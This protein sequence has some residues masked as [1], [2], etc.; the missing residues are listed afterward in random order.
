MARS[1]KRMRVSCAMCSAMSPIR[2][3]D[4]LMRSAL[5]TMR[6]SRA[7]GCWRARISI[8]S[9]SRATAFSSIIAS[10]SMTSSASATSLG[11]EGARG[12]VDRDRDEVGDLDE[13]VLNVLEGLV[14]DFAHVLHRFL[15]LGGRGTSA[16]P[17][18]WRLS[19]AKVNERCRASE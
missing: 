4:A 5:T 15:G 7:T 6:R 11:R 19:P 10:A 1:G 14:E 9:S 13:A 2:S 16:R 18:T 3:S 8:A 17:A 12:L